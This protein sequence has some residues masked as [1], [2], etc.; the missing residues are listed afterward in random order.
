MQCKVSGCL[1]IG[2]SRG[3]PNYYSK[4]WFK[5]ELSSWLKYSFVSKTDL[6]IGDKLNG[7]EH[8]VVLSPFLNYY[9]SSMLF[10]MEN[11][12]WE[13]KSNKLLGN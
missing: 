7:K 8:R 4:V 12:Y 13:L 2:P 3:V 5:N 1:D 11:S 6:G 10:K 9:K